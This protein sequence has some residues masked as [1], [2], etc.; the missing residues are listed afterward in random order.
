MINIPG[1]L[2]SLLTK[3]KSLVMEE[4]NPDLTS[5]QPVSGS[6]AVEPS[7]EIADNA[8]PQPASLPLPARKIGWGKGLGAVFNGIGV[9]L[10]LGILMGLSVSPVVS[11]VIAALSGLLAVLLGLDEKYI[12][13][14]KSIR[15]GSF[16]IATVAGVL[17]GLYVR[18]H[19]PFSPSL[20]DKKKEYMQLGF[21]EEEAKA[22]I[23]KKVVADTA[24][25]LEDDNVLYASEVQLNDCEDKLAGVKA[26]WPVSEI[27]SVFNYAGGTWG[28]FV[29][30]FQDDLPQETVGPALIAMRDSFCGK[31]SGGTLKMVNIENISKLSDNNSI[32]EIEELLS[33]PASGENWKNIVSEVRNRIPENVRKTAYLSIIKVL[34]HD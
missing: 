5:G 19:D 34:C 26:D 9:G 31:G 16:G 11:G 15:I 24:K 14:L 2:N 3:A 20:L 33:D 32:D 4:L 7:S 12:D 27:A 13:T 17:F 18:A 1:L 28:E 29:T 21:S 25:H 22:F 23:M 10:L 30:A 6:G 8:A